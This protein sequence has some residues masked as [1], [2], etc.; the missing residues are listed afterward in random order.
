MSFSANGK[1]SRSPCFTRQFFRRESPADAEILF[2][3][4][5]TKIL[6]GQAF[7]GQKIPFRF[8]KVPLSF[9]PAFDLLT[10][11][12]YR[13]NSESHWRMLLLQRERNELKS[14]GTLK[15]TQV[16]K[17]IYKRFDF[18]IK[19]TNKF[20]VKLETYIV[21]FLFSFSLAQCLPIFACTFHI[22]FLLLFARKMQVASLA[23]FLL[24]FVLFTV[25]TIP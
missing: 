25:D 19:Y 10:G 14:R 5:V 23:L 3:S 11:N 2:A 15:T 4:R 9:P 24:L 1:I 20:G 18:Y 16:V 22:L 21:C 8:L 13:A 12:D 7:Q 6:C 17:I